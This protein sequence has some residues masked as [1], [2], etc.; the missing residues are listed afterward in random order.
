MSSI[1]RLG[2]GI[3]PEE[4]GTLRQAQNDRRGAYRR[5]HDITR[6]YL[7]MISYGGPDGVGI[8]VM[9]GE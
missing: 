5:D 1:W 2:F 7:R 4:A 9:R 8:I 3:Y 6:R